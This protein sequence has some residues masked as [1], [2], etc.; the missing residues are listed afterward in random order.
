MNLMNTRSWNRIRSAAIRGS[1]AAAIACGMLL[2]PT[3]TLADSNQTYN[4]TGTLASG[5]TI[6]GT[7]TIDFTTGVVTTGPGGMT[8]DG[9]TFTCPGNGGCALVASVP[10]T[11][12]FVIVDNSQTYVFIDWNDLAPGTVPPSIPLNSGS[13]YCK[14]CGGMTG[15][16]K[17][18]SGIALAVATPEPPEALLLLA[19]LGAL[20]FLLVYRRKPRANA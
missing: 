1:L 15:F 10:G 4:V 14:N 19:G 7:V 6:T 2:I 8:V 12:G 5:G 11:E 9:M 20:G 13:T 16:D 17:A 3:A 18:T